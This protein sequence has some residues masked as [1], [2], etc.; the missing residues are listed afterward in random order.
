MSTKLVVAF[1][2]IL[3]AGWLPVRSYACQDGFYSQCLRGP[4]G[5]KIGCA[6]LPH[7]GAVTKAVTS[8]AAA[9]EKVLPDVLQVGNDVVHAN[10]AHL[11][12]SVGGLIMD[13]CTTCKAQENLL[14]SENDKP[15]LESV[16]GQGYILFLEGQSNPYL[17]TASAN[18]SVALMTEITTHG[19]PVPYPAP[20]TASTPS[21]Y[22]ASPAVCM[23]Q[24]K[25]GK[26]AAAWTSVPTFTNKATKETRPF[27]NW[28][29]SPTDTIDVTAAN[30]NCGAGATASYQK[31]VQQATMTYGSESMGT[32]DP[33]RLVFFLAGTVR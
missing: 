29:F 4:W 1:L 9:Q 10:M 5:N 22:I 21:A 18:T 19:T 3:I 17:I 13:T 7:P 14:V 28:T 12:Q 16:V 26:V 32:G 23:M 24:S 33:G 15:L 27:F 20:I 25:D 30:I 2:V 8:A 6:C 31:A 11:N